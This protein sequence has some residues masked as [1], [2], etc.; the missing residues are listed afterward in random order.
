MGFLVFSESIHKLSQLKR[1]ADENRTLFTSF[2]E[3]VEVKNINTRDISFLSLLYIF[4][5][6]IVF[7]HNITYFNSS[8]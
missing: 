4:V 7:L 5:S 2:N 6:L 3:A 1:V 8:F